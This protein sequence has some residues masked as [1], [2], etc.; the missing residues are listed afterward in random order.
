MKIKASP[1]G[2]VS[3]LVMRLPSAGVEGGSRGTA[4]GDSE[5]LHFVIPVG[6]SFIHNAANNQLHPSVIVA[7]LSRLPLPLL[8]SQL[9]PAHVL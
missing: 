7:A 9:L 1:S 6:W 5:Y 4:K 3:E 2:V 8:P